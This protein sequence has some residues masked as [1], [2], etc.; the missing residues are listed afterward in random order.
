MVLSL[1]TDYYKPVDNFYFLRLRDFLWGYVVLC[2]CIYCYYNEMSFIVILCIF[3]NK[4][5]LLLYLH[6]SMISY[7]SKN[8]ILIFILP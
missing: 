7:Y 4:V 2:L 3:L 6:V 5:M 1:P 8:K